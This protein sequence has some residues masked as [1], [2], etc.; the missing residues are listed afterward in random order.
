M[1]RAG[2]NPR[3]FVYTVKIQDYLATDTH[4]QIS[5]RQKNIFIS[6][7]CG[8]ACPVAPVD[9]NGVVKYYYKTRIVYLIYN[10]FTNS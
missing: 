8:S 5:V 3:L 6:I 10:D 4:G 9:G 1:H 7:L 2:R